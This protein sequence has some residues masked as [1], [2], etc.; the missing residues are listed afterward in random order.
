MYLITSKQVQNNEKPQQMNINVLAMKISDL[1]QRKS[2]FA[3]A[4]SWSVTDHKTLI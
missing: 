2:P 4:K 3:G 1:W